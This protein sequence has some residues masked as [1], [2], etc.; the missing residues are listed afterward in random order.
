MEEHHCP[1]AEANKAAHKKLLE[2][3]AQLRAQFEEQK[4]GTT[5]TMEIYRLMSEWLVQHIK[6]IDLKLRDLPKAV[7]VGA[8]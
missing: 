4:T 7:T 6:A 8:K 5:V 3:L 2:R 1:V